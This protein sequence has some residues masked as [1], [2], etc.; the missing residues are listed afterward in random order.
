M[1]RLVR[2]IKGRLS[3]K[4]SLM[5][6]LAMAVLLIVSLVV[7]LE[8][9]RKKVKEETLARVDLTLD[10]TMKNIDNILLSVE[11]TA[12][13]VYYSMAPHLGDPKAIDY[14]RR[15]LIKSN[16][17]VADC[18]ILFSD[19]A[20]MEPKWSVKT[21]ESDKDS[22]ICFSI[23]IE[24][25]AGK[26]IGAV[27]VDVSMRQLS[28]IVAQAKPSANSFCV[29]IDSLGSFIVHPYSERLMQQSAFE[30]SE[31]IASPD[32]SEALEAMIAGQASYRSFE[33]WGN[34]Y[35]V[36][37]KPFNRDSLRSR[38]T[39]HLGWSAGIVYPEDDIFGDYNSLTYYVLIIAFVGLLLMFLL[40][41]TVIH[42]QLQPLYMLTEQAQRIAKGHYDEP[43]PSSRHKDEIG[44]LQDNFRLMQQSLA[45]NIG[46]MDQLK[47]T[48]QERS[49]VLQAAYTKAKKADRLKTAFL[50]NMTNQMLAPAE[51]IS[52]DVEALGSLGS[53][54]NA[55]SIA[56]MVD[57]IQ[58]SGDTIAEV[59]KNL[60]NISDEEKE[61]EEGKEVTHV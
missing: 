43:I 6:V 38:T 19:S 48:L 54:A 40:S 60:L 28:R 11:Q 41:R 32:M 10:A 9:S 24:D 58:Q 5:A 57:D 49:K 27:C 39:W 51:S 3:V 59:L 22:L 20:Y 17:Y 46:E 14:Y 15:K 45:T 53:T 4:I 36:F 13:N 21:D 37:F 23:P 26:H 52:K 29:L 61:P 35:Y 7:I 44:R 2:F 42:R 25:G 47:A 16:P 33:L 30:L 12:G 56:W 1:T 50:H 31:N 18:T 34:D 55:E 8:Y